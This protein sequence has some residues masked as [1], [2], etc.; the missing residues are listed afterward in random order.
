LSPAAAQNPGAVT[1]HA[2]VIGKGPGQTGFTSLLCGS[3][4]LA[5][6][7]SAADPICQTITGDVT[8]TAAG[9][10][11]IGAAKVTSAMLRDSAA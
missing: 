7:Q 8:I 11:A 3:A 10:T 1:S 5:V 9:V 4:Q 6:G 2:F